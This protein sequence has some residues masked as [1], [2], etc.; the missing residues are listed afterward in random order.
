MT[1]A[2]HE[3]PV[4]LVGAP[5]S[6][7]SLVYKALCLHPDASYVSNWVRLFPA[8]PQLA[9]LNRAAT[10][11]PELRRRVWF[12]GGENAYVYGQR[13]P[14][15]ERAFPMPVEGEPLYARAGIGVGEHNGNGA[16]RGVRL[17]QL[18]KSFATVRRAGG[19]AAVVNKRVANN[20]RIPLLLDAFPRARFVEIVRDG[21]AVALSLANVDWWPES[22]VWW[23]GRTP[24]QWEASGRDPWELCA[25]TWVEELRA[26]EAGLGAVPVT[27]RHSIT[28]E[29]L[30]ADP[31]GTLDGVVAFAGLDPSAAGA[32]WLHDVRFPDRNEAWRTRLEP[33]AVATIE[34]V[35]GDDLRRHGYA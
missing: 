22:V 29:Q 19:G 1:A 17:D 21:R 31:Y 26:A 23:C 7:T 13:R 35:Q 11:L 3:A 12:S 14:L 16:S 2:D 27:Q 6:G 33:R 32:Q 15:W 30:V 5:R 34:S 9:V 24:R 20:R 28:Y 18:R 4:F 10:R 8:V 25:R